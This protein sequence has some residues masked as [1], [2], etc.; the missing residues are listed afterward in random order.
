MLAHYDCLDIF[1]GDRFKFISMK[2]LLQF[3]KDYDCRYRK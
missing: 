3:L 2:A 1:D